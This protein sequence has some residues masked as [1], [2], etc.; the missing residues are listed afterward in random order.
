MRW[1]RP[2]WFA[3]L[4]I[5]QF[6]RFAGIDLADAALPMASYECLEDLFVRR[7]VNGARSIDAA[8]TAV[9]SPVD[10][11]V[12]ERGRI[13]R[14]M[15]LQVKGRAYGL[16][17]LLGDAQV[18][19]RLE[20]GAYVTLYLAPHNYHRIHS[21][22]EAVVVEASHLP[23]RLL[24]VFPAATETVADLFVRNERIV[25]HLDVR[26]AGR[27]VL[28]NVGATLVGHLTV[29]YDPSLGTGAVSGREVGHRRYD[30]P[31]PLAKGA[32]LGAFELGSTVVLAAEAG[33]MT[34][35]ELRVGQV[36]R[37]GERIGTL[38]DANRR[39]DGGAGER[40]G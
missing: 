15:L 11:R 28:V 37:V 30:P 40:R 31:Q 14:G 3:R 10:G 38:G 12:G 24:P 32:E 35:S 17:D 29:T 19:Q 9:T 27:M 36:V 39:D 33:C 34:L 16:A 22:V 21:P 23:G 5:R 20:G 6:V 7:L 2:R 13:E 25:T 1:R 8:A 18:A 26:G 4:L